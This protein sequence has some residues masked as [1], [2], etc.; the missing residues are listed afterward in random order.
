MRNWNVYS[1]SPDPRKTRASSCRSFRCSCFP[2]RAR[3]RADAVSPGPISRTSSLERRVQGLESDRVSFLESRLASLEAEVV[4][5]RGLRGDARSFP[6]PGLPPAANPISSF[7]NRSH[8]VSGVVLPP[9]ASLAPI[10]HFLNN[11]PHRPPPSPALPTSPLFPSPPLLSVDTFQGYI[12]RSPGD[13]SSPSGSEA[14]PSPASSLSQLLTGDAWRSAEDPWG[15]RIPP[16]S[17]H[18]LNESRPRKVRKM[19]EDPP[20]T[21]AGGIPLCEAEACVRA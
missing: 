8:T 5:L 13:L 20:R 1:Q 4:A 10:S 15:S 17:L 12:N 11:A 9:I 19:R 21:E 18:L 7:R 14:A 16:S 3:S 2:G 6:P